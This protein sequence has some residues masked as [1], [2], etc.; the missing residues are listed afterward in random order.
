MQEPKNCIDEKSFNN[1]PKRAPCCPKFCLKH[2]SRQRQTVNDQL[3]GNTANFSSF[4]VNLF[5]YN[6]CN[7]SNEWPNHCD[8]PFWWRQTCL[9]ESM[10]FATQRLHGA[11]VIMV[12]SQFWSSGKCVNVPF[13]QLICWNFE[14]LDDIGVEHGLCHFQIRKIL[15][16]PNFHTIQTNLAT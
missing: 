6:S 13:F 8:R 16:P 9:R 15:G 1:V 7:E 4:L 3:L 14:D 10:T 12:L 11:F 2:K 5:L